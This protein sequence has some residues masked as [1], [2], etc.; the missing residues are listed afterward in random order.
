VAV[1]VRAGAYA[2]ISSDR[3][4]DGL[5]VARQLQDCE[6]LAA[7]KGWTVAERYVDDDVSA[8]SGKARPQYARLLEDLRS[9]AI[10]AVVVYHLDRLHRQPKELEEF[11]EVCKD[12]GVDQL[13]SVT[14]RIDLA[15]ADGQF[16]AR[17]LGAVAKKES[18]DKEPPHPPQA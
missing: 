6:E 13:A 15:N 8:Y 11:F 7:S 18:D 1:A 9:G 17:I 5:G 3:E 14:G 2:R 10:N 4:G 12:S 16:M